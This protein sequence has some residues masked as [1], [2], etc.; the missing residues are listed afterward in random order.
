[1]SVAADLYTV[2]RT[3][4]VLSFDFVGYS[5]GFRE[6]LPNRAD[7]PLLR[8]YESYDRFLRR[9]THPDPAAR[10][11]SAEEMAE[12]LLGVLREVVAHETG[13]PRPAESTVFFPGTAGFGEVVTH[14]GELVPLRPTAEEVAAAL[15][16][17]RGELPA[18]TRGRDALANGR[19][20]EAR[21]AFD[22][23]YTALP[24]ELAPQ[25]ALAAA[26]ELDNDPM[27]AAGRYARVWQTDHGRFDAAY[28]LARAD[29][30]LG[31]A[32][33]A[34]VV[35]RA[36]TGAAP[37]ADPPG[38]PRRRLV[39]WRSFVSGVADALLPV[40]RLRT[41]PVPAW[42]RIEARLHDVYDRLGPPVPAGKD[43][44]L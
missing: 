28:G 6:A 44:T 24:G 32:D 42:H 1:M 23:V 39:P 41:P 21:A 38:P 37:P 11:G 34:Q 30:A 4:A 16:E 18:W 26:A 35:L 27:A 20:A 43:P 14:Y 25:L 40:P 12:Q 5:S 36:V 3:L 8:Q 17:P 15:P 7:V 29:L 31:D 2:G 33:R 9:A 19:V 13:I 22:E 10:F